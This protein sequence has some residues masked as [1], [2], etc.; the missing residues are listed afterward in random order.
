MPPQPPGLGRPCSPQLSRIPSPHGFH[1]L[2]LLL[3]QTR[4]FRCIFATPP[5]EAQGDIQ[6][7]VGR[8]RRRK[9]LPILSA[10]PVEKFLE[11][12][13]GGFPLGCGRASKGVRSEGPKKGVKEG[14]EEERNSSTPGLTWSKGGDS[15]EL[16]T[17]VNIIGCYVAFC[18]L[19]LTALGVKSVVSFGPSQLFLYIVHK[20]P[21]K[22]PT[23]TFVFSMCIG[24]YNT[25]N[26]S[27]P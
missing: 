20:P 7:K 2:L 9:G 14:K 11:G 18:G 17:F 22:I 6:K 15:G 23:H 12:E 8:R 26:C 5:G 21:P 3:L 4:S 10:S 25:H 16:E 27:D 19:L 24:Y 1:L 13:G